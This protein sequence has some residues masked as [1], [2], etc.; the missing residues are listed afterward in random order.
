MLYA[1]T[2][3]TRIIFNNWQSFTIACSSASE[4]V[5]CCSVQCQ[6]GMIL[7]LSRRLIDELSINLVDVLTRYLATAPIKEAYETIKDISH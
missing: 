3:L 2:L 1:L 5:L 7:C 4:K 6:T